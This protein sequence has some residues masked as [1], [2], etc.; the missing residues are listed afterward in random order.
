M[1]S[2]LDKAKLEQAST[3]LSSTEA[4]WKKTFKKKSEWGADRYI[5]EAR[6]IELEA[7]TAGVVKSR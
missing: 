3:I 2:F 1:F 5:D 4:T 7:A 6:L